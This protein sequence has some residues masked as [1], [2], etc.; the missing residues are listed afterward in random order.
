MSPF[1]KNKNITSLKLYNFS[2]RGNLTEKVNPLSQ[3]RGEVAGELVSGSVSLSVSR[4]PST[5]FRGQ[6]VS[7][8]IAVSAQHGTISMLDLHKG[9]GRGLVPVPL[10]PCTFPG[11][12]CPPS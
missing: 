3:V 6:G 11:R 10:H 4:D 2:F 5:H 8:F 12:A 1:S 7:E 9:R